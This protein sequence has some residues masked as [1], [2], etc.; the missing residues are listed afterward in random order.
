MKAIGIKI[1][2][3]MPIQ[4]IGRLRRRITHTTTVEEIKNTFTKEITKGNPYAIKEYKKIHPDYGSDFDLKKLIKTAHANGMYVVLDW[5][6]NHTAWDHSWIVTHPEWYTKNKKGTPIAPYNWIDV[7]QLNYAS[8][9][10]HFAMID[11]MKYWVQKFNIDGF[12]C[13]VAS[14]VPNSF[15]GTSCKRIEKNKTY[16]NDC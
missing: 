4:E 15:L 5:V 9:D 8:V 12:R 2:W 13:Q 14:E 10:L 1:I 16:F 7:A 3:L 6:A 11:E